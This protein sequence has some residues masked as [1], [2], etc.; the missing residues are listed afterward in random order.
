[1]QASGCLGTIAVQL[2]GV[3]AYRRHAM[4]WTN[5]H[6]LERTTKTVYKACNLA[7]LMDS[8]IAHRTGKLVDA[9]R[10]H[11]RELYQFIPLYAGILGLVSENINPAGRTAEN[12]S[13]RPLSSNRRMRRAFRNGRSNIARHCFMYCAVPTPR[14]QHSP[15]SRPVSSAAATP[16]PVN[17]SV[18]ARASPA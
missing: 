10:E 3:E 18:K 15:A 5:H 2:P 12:F 4:E 17:G 6:T 16:E 9:I 7:L 1:M 13:A 8:P 11:I 14:A